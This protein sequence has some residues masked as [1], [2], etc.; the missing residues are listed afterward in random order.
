MNNTSLDKKYGNVSFGSGSAKIV[1][2]WIVSLVNGK[3]KAQNELLVEGLKHNLLSISQICDQAHNV[4]L[5][6]KDCEIRQSYSGKFVAK[7]VRTI[8]NVYI[9][10]ENQEEKCYM[11]QVDKIGCGTSDWDI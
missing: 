8:D 1:G 6:A 10:N 3:R 4:L 7:G 5:N 11:G 2:K 9:L